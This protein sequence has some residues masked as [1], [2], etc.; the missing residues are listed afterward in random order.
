MTRFA[1]A[2]LAALAACAAPK[3]DAETTDTTDTETTDR[4]EDVLPADDATDATDDAAEP[5]PLPA[6]FIVPPANADGGD[7]WQLFGYKRAQAMVR[8]WPELA[9]RPVLVT[10]IRLRR[11]QIDATDLG[12]SLSIP[13]AEVWVDALPGDELTS[14][15]QTFADNLSANAQRVFQGTLNVAAAD[16]VSLAYDDVVLAV[17]PPFAFDPNGALLLLDFRF[18]ETPGVLKFDCRNDA[19]V[20]MRM[21]SGNPTD[22]TVADNSTGCGYSLEIEVSP[23]AN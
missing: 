3:D 6:S 10:G 4:A 20:W 22:T 13:N 19:T 11:T 1:F 9:G 2:A 17:E 21:I 14:L 5:A 16:A 8:L 7:N 23:P 15:S 12:T 18:P